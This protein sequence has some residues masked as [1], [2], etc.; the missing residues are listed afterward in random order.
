MLTKENTIKTLKAKIEACSKGFL[1]EEKKGYV[2][3][4]DIE[5]YVFGQFSDV[6]N[7]LSRFYE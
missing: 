2:S 4:Q 1:M 3:Q 5:D 6:Y 7:R